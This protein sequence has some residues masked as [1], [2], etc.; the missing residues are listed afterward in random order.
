MYATRNTG[1][2]NKHFLSYIGR[3]SVEKGRKEAGNIGIASSNPL[4]R[5][6]SREQTMHG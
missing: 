1:N 3:D 4:P 5:N 6:G 2:V